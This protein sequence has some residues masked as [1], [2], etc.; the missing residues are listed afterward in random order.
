MPAELASL[1]TERVPVPTIGIGAGSGCDGQVLVSTDLLGI[2]AGL[3]LRFVKRYAELGPAVERAFA[4]YV[5]D[6]REGRFPAAEHTFSMKPAIAEQVRA[7]LDGRER[8]KVSH[9]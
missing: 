1:I 6:V 9:R 7:V 2:D 5:A 4:A 3:S 8:V